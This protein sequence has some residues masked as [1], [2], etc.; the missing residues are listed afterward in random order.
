M[1]DLVMPGQTAGTTVFRCAW[2]CS[3]CRGSIP[4]KVIILPL[5]CVLIY[6]NGNGRCAF[7]LVA[8][9]IDARLSRLNRWTISLSLDNQLVRLYSC[10]FGFG[11]VIWP[12]WGHNS[13]SHPC[14]NI[15]SWRWLACVYLCQNRWTIS[16]GLDKQRV[17]LYCSVF[18]FGAVLGYMP[19]HNTYDCDDWCAFILVASM[20][21]SHWPCINRRYVYILVCLTWKVL[22][23]FNAVQDDNL[24]LI[25]CTMMAMI[26]VRLSWLHWWNGPV[27]LDEQDVC[28]YFCML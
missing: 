12:E 13:T 17:R 28:L 21:R 20:E 11:R 18:H 26:G 14:Q 24:T 19:C 4:C 25:P 8:A 3:C 7:M 22:C 16:L 15:P 23:A 6:Y 9:M 27:G 2:L 10:L 1:N 5:F